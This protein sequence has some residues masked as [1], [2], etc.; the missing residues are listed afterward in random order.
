MIKTK[1]YNFF[2]YF[3]L[4]IFSFFYNF[5][6][7][8]RGVFPID[9]FLHYDSAYKI[10][11]GEI[12]VR[13]FWVIHGLTIDYIQ[14]IF[15]YIFG[16]SWISYISHSSIFN[17]IMTLLVF[18][19][20]KKLGINVLYTFI[21]SICFSILA[22]PI[23]GV[24]FID[25][26]A[27][28]FSVI[29]LLFFYYGIEKKNY[30]FF[31]F[32]PFV[33]GLAFFSKPV[34][35]TYIL[36]LLLSLLILCLYFT[37]DLKILYSFLIGTLAVL[38]SIFFFLVLQD[39]PLKN[40]LD[41]LFLYPVSIGGK[42]FEA[43]L[44]SMQNRIFNFKFLIIPILFLIYLLFYK[45]NNS[46]VK[47]ID[48]TISF[49]I[50]ALNLILI[51]HQLLTKNQNFIFFLIPINIGL[52]IYIGSKTNFKYKN[53]VNVIFLIATIILTIK[54]NERFNFERKFH[55]LQ[56]VNL[57]TYSEASKINKALYPLKWKSNNFSKTQEEINLINRI[58]KIINTSNKN[59]LLI[60]N[61]NFLDS[62]TSKRLY[63]VVK[64]Y[65]NV[66]I[67]QKNNKYYI[68][69]KTFFNQKL[70]DKDIGEIIFFVPN[71]NT[72]EIRD[73]FNN[74]FTEKCFDLEKLDKAIIRL[75]LKNC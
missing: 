74:L 53:Y 29:G 47:K 55:D 42:R 21:L 11:N 72:E 33:F 37:R 8:N 60:T 4:G 20:F 45:K 50:I 59:I 30:N 31:I 69:F 32:I 56:N 75:S 58:I 73:N 44:Y 48:L 71:L 14:S 10:L 70:I 34:P 36:I 54:Y 16:T 17:C 64:T 26:H 28:F 19:F 27:T 66:T 67:P 39:I 13:D 1:T 40:F 25:H 62:I 43:I 65:D 2:L 52:I 61:Y 46:R 18:N 68:T 7:S 3:L 63:S 23:S 24:P 5:W 15:F 9:T 35:T 51:L 41:Q 38:I 6:V 49:A 12:P 22:Y 57:N